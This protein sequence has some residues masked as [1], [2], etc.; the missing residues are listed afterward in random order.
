[1]NLVLSYLQISALCVPRFLTKQRVDD[2]KTKTGGERSATVSEADGDADKNP[3]AERDISTDS[4]LTMQ[5][6]SM[7]TL[8]KVLCPV[9]ERDISTDSTLT[10]QGLSMSTLK[11][12]LC[13]YVCSH[14][15]CFT[16]NTNISHR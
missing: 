14:G 2:P 16:T 7:S 9:A 4:T 13:T 12:V 5:G 15:I 1:M 8:K 3:V 10:M 6:L 11:K